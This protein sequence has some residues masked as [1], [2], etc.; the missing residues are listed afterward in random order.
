MGLSREARAEYVRIARLHGWP[1]GWILAVDQLCLEVYCHVGDSIRDVER[2]LALAKG[3]TR[4]RLRKT[5]KALLGI[6]KQ[7]AWS[8]GL[9]P[10]S[11]L[12][13]QRAMRERI[14]L[15]DELLPPEKPRRH[16]FRKKPD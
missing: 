14:G 8:L 12:L 2:Q 3:A 7:G 16:V 5:L 6:R 4:R 15:W 10:E 1:R 11:R 9:V 13:I